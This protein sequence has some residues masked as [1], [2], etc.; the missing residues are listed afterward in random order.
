MPVGTPATELIATDIPVATPLYVTSEEN[1]GRRVDVPK[2]YLGLPLNQ[3]H[4][5][6]LL[7]P[8]V[9]HSPEVC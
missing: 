1:R 6:K 7:S 4:Q 9:Q 2:E 3:E 8:V 5:D